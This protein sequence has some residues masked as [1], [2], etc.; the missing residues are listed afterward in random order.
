MAITFEKQCPEAAINLCHP[1]MFCILLH[2]CMIQ[3]IV[4]QCSAVQCSAVQC[5]AVQCTELHCTTL[6]HFTVNISENI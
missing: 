4:V 1:V 5:N 6:L 3:C 2:F